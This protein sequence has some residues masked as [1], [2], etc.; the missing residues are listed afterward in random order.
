MTISNSWEINQQLQGH[1][2]YCFARHREDKL[3]FLQHGSLMPQ[4]IHILINI[5]V[6][7]TTMKD[8]AEKNGVG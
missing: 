4:M 2:T 5:V 6:I 8:R 1:T 3:L 7:L